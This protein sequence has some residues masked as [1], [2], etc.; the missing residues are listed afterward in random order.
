MA[1]NCTETYINQSNVKTN[2]STNINKGLIKSTLSKKANTKDKNEK[3][4][5]MQFIKSSLE[6]QSEHLKKERDKLFKLNINKE[7]KHVYNQLTRNENE[8]TKTNTKIKDNIP[9]VTLEE[10]SNLSG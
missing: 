2:N 3:E 10:L 1:I 5:N 6:E 9:K 4:K 8:K 7:I